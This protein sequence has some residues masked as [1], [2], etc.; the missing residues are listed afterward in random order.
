MNWCCMRQVCSW[1]T[2]WHSRRD[3]TELIKAD[4]SIYVPLLPKTSIKSRELLLSGAFRRLN[5]VNVS[6]HLFGVQMKVHPGSLK[7]CSKN[8]EHLYL[9]SQAGKMPCCQ[10]PDIVPAS[11]CERECP[12]CGGER[13]AGIT[14]CQE[15][16][17]PQW[18]L[19]DCWRKC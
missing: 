3:S 18:C 2:L 1:K 13:T 9:G 11:C 5:L 6:K 16:S 10:T 19:W 7:K 17:C 15:S 12:G 8:I 14:V 4:Y